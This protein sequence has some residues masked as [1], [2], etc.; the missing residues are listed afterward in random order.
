[1][2]GTNPDAIEAWAFDAVTF[3]HLL[4]RLE[5][6]RRVVLLSGDVHYSAG[7][8][9]SYW[10]GS[11]DPAGPVRAVHLERLQERDADDD[12]RR[13]PQ[14]RLRPADGPRQPRHRAASAGTS[15]L[16]D[17][18]LLPEGDD[19]VDLV[20]AMRARLA[21][22]AGAW[23][24]P[25]AGR[26]TTTPS[27]GALRSRA[28]SSRLNPATPPDWRW[29]VKPLLD[30]RARR[31]TGRSRSGR[32][33]ST[34]TQ[35]D[36]ELADPATRARRL[37]GGRRPPPARPRP[38]AQRP[39]DPVPR[40]RRAVRFDEP[41]RTAGSR[42]CT[43]STPR[44]PT[45]TSRRRRAQGR[46]LPACRG[47]SL[48]PEDEDPPE[49]AARRR[50][51][52][53]RATRCARWPAGEQ[54]VLPVPRRRGVDFFDFV[55][56]RVARATRRRPAALIKD[57]GGNRTIS[58][59][60][61]AGL[62]D[63]DSW[64][65]SRPTATRRNPTAEAALAALADI[66]AAP[67][68]ARQQRRS[69]VARRRSAQ[70]SRPARPRRCST[71]SPATTSGCASRGCSSSCRPSRCSRSRPRPTAPARTI[72]SGSAVAFGA[73]GTSCSARARLLEDLD[74]GARRRCRRSSTACSSIGSS[75]GV[76]PPRRGGVGWITATT[77]SSITGD[78]LTG[79]DAPGLDIDSPDAAD[80]APTSSP[81]R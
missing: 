40:Q 4:E 13:R 18:V 5:P 52:R 1:M 46:A 31:P 14:R 80:R 27:D 23:S 57:L 36:A 55:Q 26:T 38:P 78:V 67:R 22:D 64:T 73:L 41:R 35:V 49:P 8:V 20:P 29:R 53:S 21:V 48:G 34:T 58:T 69:L 76:L 66:A 77:R 51:S 71:C 59:R 56:A 61:H 50:R 44:S 43:R 72:S 9:M 37:P 15:P 62:P 17:M 12:H 3:E 74:P 54:D 75:D 2:T 39:P 68:R 63:R 60:R 30:D 70:G 81:A 7:T 45:R 11:G 25:G 33:S 47:R 28:K 6:Y 24:R 19:R 32:W 10:R 16:E 79:W 65:R 42:R